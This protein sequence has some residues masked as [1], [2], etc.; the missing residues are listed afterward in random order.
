M[1][2]QHFRLKEYPFGIT[3]DTS[4]FFSSETSQQ[5]LNTL[6]VAARTGEG[7]I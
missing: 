4:F 6:L 3:P 5:A 1:Y 2:A 7:F